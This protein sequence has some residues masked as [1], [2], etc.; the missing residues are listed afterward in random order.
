MSKL[1]VNPQLA[2]WDAAIAEMAAEEAGL[3][4]EGRWVTGPEDLLSVVGLARSELVHSAA[5]AWL[6]DPRGRHGLGIGFLERFLARCFPEEVFAGLDDARCEVELP[7][8]MA[9]ADIVIWGEDWMVLIENKVDAGEQPD[10]CDTYFQLFGEEVGPHFVFLTPSG[11]APGTANGEAAAA[12]RSLSYPAVRD[13]LRAALGAKIDR[14]SV[15]YHSAMAYLDT[16]ERLF[17]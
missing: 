10:Q 9:R 17:P 14:A 4:A 1:E 11:R 2:G 16:I 8:G 15:G 7:R 5:L 3:R 13:E 12:F 6:L